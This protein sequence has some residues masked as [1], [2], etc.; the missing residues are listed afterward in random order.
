MTPAVAVAGRGGIHPGALLKV[1]VAWFSPRWRGA[2]VTSMAFRRGREAAS[3]RLRRTIVGREGSGSA[4]LAHGLTTY[5][6]ARGRG[7]E[8]MSDTG[9]KALCPVSVRGTSRGVWWYC[10]IGY[11]R[12]QQGVFNDLLLSC[13]HILVY[14]SSIF[15]DHLGIPTVWL[16]IWQFCVW[17]QA[18]PAALDSA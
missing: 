2:F 12:S 8:R 16:R 4:R 1:D 7:S 18:W 10:A 3:A 6:S 13:R 17:K 11:E 14:L 5:G 15:W 9:H